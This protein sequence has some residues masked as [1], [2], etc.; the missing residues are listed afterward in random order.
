MQTWMTHDL[1]ADLQKL[2]SVPRLRQLFRIEVDTTSGI[3]LHFTNSKFLRS[4]LEF[5]FEKIGQQSLLS[6]Y[7][8]KSI[9]R[10]HFES[11]ERTRPFS[12]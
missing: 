9:P 12:S 7:F 10:R 8:F 2:K 3:D 6:E 5:G 11:L 4:I 1:H